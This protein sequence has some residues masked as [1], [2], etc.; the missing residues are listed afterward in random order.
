MCS[1]F[2]IGSVRFVKFLHE[3]MFISMFI[4]LESLKKALKNSSKNPPQILSGRHFSKNSCRK[5]WSRGIMF[6]CHFILENPSLVSL[7]HC[8]QKIIQ[9]F[10]K[11]YSSKHFSGVPQ[12]SWVPPKNNAGTPFLIWFHSKIFQK[13]LPLGITSGN[14]HRM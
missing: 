14:P 10:V 2:C 11:N 1:L 9:T 6:E 4:I 12:R 3:L 8:F 5:Q 13:E 7:E